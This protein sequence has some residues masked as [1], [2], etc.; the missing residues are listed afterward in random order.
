M[1]YFESHWFS[2]FLPHLRLLYDLGPNCGGSVRQGHLLRHDVI[3][4]NLIKCLGLEGMSIPNSSFSKK[5]SGNICWEE[6]TGRKFGGKIL[7][8]GMPEFLCVCYV[9]I[10]M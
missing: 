8:A 1:L 5:D 2:I 10:V 6:A 7:S 3:T 4:Q 9:N